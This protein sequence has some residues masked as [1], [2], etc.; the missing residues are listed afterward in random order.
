MVSVLWQSSHCTVEFNFLSLT[1][2]RFWPIANGESYTRSIKSSVSFPWILRAPIHHASLTTLLERHGGEALKPHVREDGFIWIQTF[3]HHC[4][5][6]GSEASCCCGFFRPELPAAISA[7]GQLNSA[8]ISNPQTHYI[9]RG[10]CF[11]S[12]S[13]GT[14]CHLVRNN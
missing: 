6:P 8:G 2:W 3:R 10:C 5:V 14:V 1:L 9:L 13:F 12:P 4:Q 11:K 7:I